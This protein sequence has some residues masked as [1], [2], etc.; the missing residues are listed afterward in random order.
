MVAQE[1]EMSYFDSPSVL[2]AELADLQRSTLPMF[3]YPLL[4]VPLIWLVHAAFRDWSQDKVYLVDVAVIELVVSAFL[5][6]EIRHARY[7][8][9]AW[10]FI[11][12]LSLA[13]CLLIS[14]QPHPVLVAFGLAVVVVAQALLS[15]AQSVLASVLMWSAAITAW[16]LRAGAYPPSV[17]LYGTLFLYALIWAV[18]RLSSHP[19][20]TSIS[21]ALAA[22][23]SGRQLL[24]EARGRRAELYRALRALEEATYRIERMNGELLVARHQADETRD[25]KARFVA[26][27]SHELRGPL[28]L[29]L[30]ASV[31]CRRGDHLPQQ[32]ASC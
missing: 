5:V 10:V 23:K 32:P 19:L 14:F 15:P 26:T 31:S 27:V 3:V 18:A 16:R 13:I 2:D 17:T 20:R 29:I 24:E 30:G 28:N 9:A 7:A 25:Q 12:S 11:L 21:W 8:L 6:L 22:W 1:R 4:A